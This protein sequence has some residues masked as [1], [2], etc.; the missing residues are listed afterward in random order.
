MRTTLHDMLGH[1]CPRFAI[2][3]EVLLPIPKPT[4]YTGADPYKISLQVGRENFHTPWLFM[5]GRQSS[6]VPMLDIQLKYS[7]GDLLG[8][9]A[10][11]ENMPQQYLKQHEAVMKQFWDVENWPKYILVRYHWD[12]KSN[13]DVE[14]GLYILFGSG[15]TLTLVT[16]LHILQSSKEK[17]ARFVKETVVANAVPGE[18]AKVE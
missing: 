5:I 6:D 9:V 3:R 10:K 16:A 4:G 14:A 18:E 11:V 13:V 8:V 17:L 12:E 7:G 2:D 1:H 15:F